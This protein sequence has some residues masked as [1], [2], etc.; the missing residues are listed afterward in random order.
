MKEFLNRYMAANRDLGNQNSEELT[1]VFDATVSTIVE[2]IGARAFRPRSALNAAVLDAVMVGL[3]AR[4][5]SSPNVNNGDLAER[6][7]KLV[8]LREFQ[9]ATERSTA[10]EESVRQ[11]LRLAREA[12]AN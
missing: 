10:D 5:Q 9:Q 11:R 1:G 3:A 2:A 6:Y 4:L 8:A 12:F 7:G